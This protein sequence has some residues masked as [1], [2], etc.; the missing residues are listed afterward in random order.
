M[1]HAIARCM[2]RHNWSDEDQALDRI[3]QIVRLGGP[4]DTPSGSALRLGHELIGISRDRLGGRGWAV[5]TYYTASFGKARRAYAK[6]IRLLTFGGKP[7]RSAA[8]RRL[9]RQGKHCR[10]R[11]LPP[12]GTASSEQDQSEPE[13]P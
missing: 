6:D 5:V 3:L 9:K 4:V 7:G 10:Q 12:W 2:D 8:W 1:P 11:P 13:P